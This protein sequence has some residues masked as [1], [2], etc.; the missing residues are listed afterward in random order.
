[1]IHRIF[2]AAAA[3]FLLLGTA[4]A[5]HADVMKTRDGQ[6]WPKRIQKDMDGQD[7]PSDA[8]LKKSGRNNLELAYDNVE[9]GGKR[10]SAAEVEEIYPTAAYENLSFRNGERQAQ[11]RY[12]SEAAANFAEAAENLKGASKELALYNRVVCLAQTGN[13]AKTFDAAQQLLDAFPKTYYFAKVQDIRARILINRRNRRG[14]EEELNKVINAPGMNARDYFEAK[15]AIIYLFKFKQAGKDTKIYAQARADYERVAREIKA[16]SAQQVAAIQL[17]KAEVGQGKCHVY[18]GSFEE[19][20]PHFTRVIDDERSLQDQGLLA[21]AYTG[22]GDVRYAKIKK[23][24]AAGNVPEDQLPRIIAALTDAA[25]DYVRV[26]KFYVES[27]GDDLYPATVGAARV[28]ATHFTLTGEK[29]CVLA[30]RAAKYF[31][32]AHKLLKRGETR[33]LLTS[34]VKRFLAKRDEACKVP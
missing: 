10:V 17:L 26:S 31:F 9:V 20:L 34:E 13:A 21:Q 27:A 19:A 25:L 16:R 22:R 11:S 6:W 33:R 28:W 32:A 4:H 29:D 5:A 12:W 23:E 14:A 24:L 8:V 30:K 3:A 2:G 7:A 1:M 18:E 15:L